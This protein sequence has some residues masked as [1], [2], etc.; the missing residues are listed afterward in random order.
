[1]VN[2]IFIVWFLVLIAFVTFVSLGFVWFF[3]QIYM[4]IKIT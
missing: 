1:M 2:L 3:H 4:N